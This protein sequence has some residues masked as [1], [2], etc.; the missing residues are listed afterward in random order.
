M[1]MDPRGKV[2][3][4][5]LKRNAYLYVR[6]SSLKQVFHNTESTQRQYALKQRAIALGWGAEQI[7]VI[8]ADL[9]QSGASAADRAGFQELV[10]DVGLGKAG[11]VMGLEVSRL[12]RNNV[13]WHRLLEIC[14]LTDTLI[15]DEDGIYDPAHFNDRLLLGLKGTM[16]EAELHLLR[17]RLIGGMMS[18]AK[19]GELRSPLSIGFVY[20]AA[21][22]VVFD[23]DR[24]VQK[25]LR[26]FFET[27]QRTGSAMATVKYFRKEKLRFPSRIRNGPHKGEVAWRQLEHH[28]ALW[29]LH[30][31][32]Y[33]G[34]FF[35]G[36]SRQR[37]HGDYRYKL[38]PRDEWIALIRDAHPGYISWEEFE[39]NQLRLQENSAV[40]GSDRRKSPPREGPALL[41]GLAICGKCGMRMTV[42]YNTRN[43]KIRPQYVC[44][45]YGIERG[46][47]VCQYIL[48][49]S[50][51]QAVGALVLEAVSP[52]ALEV[53]LAV[54]QELEERAEEAD[55]LRRKAVERAQYEADLARRRYMKVDPENR[56]VADTLEADWNDKL[57]VLDQKQEEYKRQREADC[58]LLDEKK[59][60]RIL[61]LTNDFPKL[62]NDPATPD[63]ERKRMLRFLIDDVTLIKGKEL[64]THVR[65]RGGA[66]KTLRLPRPLPAYKIRQSSDG[67]IAEIDRLLNHNT[68]GETAALLNERGIRS[69]EGKPLNGLMIR[70]LRIDHKLKS[71]YERLREAGFLTGEEVAKRLG[72]APSTVKAWRHAGWVK[73]VAYNDK[74][75]YLYETPGQDAPVKYKWKRRSC[76]QSISAQNGRSAV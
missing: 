60:A 51:D 57:R 5:H 34:A 26:L 23:P 33:A 62:W 21:D 12:A 14:A 76:R 39:Q 61:S 2:Q 71:R 7:I 38:L 72:I 54:Q 6:Q 41:Q 29:L 48:G 16:S 3:S 27:F 25:T 70:R 74:P 50:I 53:S 37:K 35:Y 15:L 75:E 24:Q 11:I 9:G 52:V 69:Y 4:R 67:L 63:R 42:R 19:R 55:A 13:D 47:P 44:Q 65:F 68:D 36:R 58:M 45:R 32:R 30:N 73:A 31:P 17:A 10:A 59:R 20:D 64:I 22:R 43:G 46:E 28:R 49:D 66:T 40:H 56:L 1:N 18:K 8:D